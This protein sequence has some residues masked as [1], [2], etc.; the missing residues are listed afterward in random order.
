MFTGSAKPRQCV[1]ALLSH[2]VPLISSIKPGCARTGTASD[3]Q[4]SVHPGNDIRLQFAIA[5]G[6]H[7]EYKLDIQLGE[8]VDR[9]RRPTASTY[10]VSHILRL[11]SSWLSNAQ[12]ALTHWLRHF[13]TPAGS[14]KSIYTHQ[15]G[16]QI[17]LTTSRDTENE[18]AQLAC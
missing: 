14:P 15:T 6:R 17:A 4:H 10:T 12:I 3:K 2:D 11:N 5:L 18:P 13:T 16:A 8:Q 9:L 1:Q 7:C